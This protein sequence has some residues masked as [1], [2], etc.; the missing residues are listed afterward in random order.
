MTGATTWMG[1][2]DAMIYYLTREVGVNEGF[3]KFSSYIQLF[4]DASYI[5]IDFAPTSTTTPASASGT[6]SV[7]P[8]VMSVQDDGRII[9]A[10]FEDL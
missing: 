3:C 9:Y 8:T 10:G 1:Y 7:F 6:G 4:V 5:L 2:F